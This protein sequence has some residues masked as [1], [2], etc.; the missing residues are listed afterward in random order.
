MGRLGHYHEGDRS[1]FRVFAP[2]RREIAVVLDGGRKINM[3][4]DEL[5]YWNGSCEH[6][7]Y[8][9]RY[10]VEVNGKAYPDPASK[11]QPNGVH[12]HS[13]VTEI[14]K[15]NLDDWKGI[16]MEDAIIYEL[17]LGTFTE[18]GDLRG[19]MEKLT[20]LQELGINVIELMPLNAFPGKRNWGYDGTYQFALQESYGTYADLKDFIERA[21]SLGIAVILDV[22]YNHFG[23][24]GNYTGVFAN[25]TK[26]A[27]TP[28][29]AAINFDGSYNYGIREFY[30]ENARYW[31]EDV[32]FDGFR[33]DAVSL[34]F[35][36]MPV[37]ILREI[38]DLVRGIAHKEDRHIIN[39]AEHLRNDRFVTNE[40][41]FNYDSQWNDDMNHAIYAKVTGE[42]KG[43]YTNFGGFE[44]V[45]KAMS[46]GFVLDGSRY[47]KYCR[48]FMGTSGKKT[49]AREHVVH[50]QN[51]DQLGNRLMGDRMIASY[52]LEKALLGIAAVL[53]TP[54]VP[55]LF[56]GEEYGEKA[57]FLFFE[58]FEDPKLVEAVKAGRK[59]EYGFGN[60]EPEPPHDIETFN[61][62]KLRWDTLESDEGSKI[63]GYY[64]TLLGLKKA[65]KLGPVDKEKVNIEADNRREIIKVITED[66][67]T[68]L[69]FSD[70]RH[71]IGKI[72]ELIISSENSYISKEIAPY[73]AQVYRG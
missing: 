52:G 30:L 59:R 67:I 5:G 27:P 31:L 6:L 39:I 24:E 32:G 10:K 21:H 40:S 43:H 60:I 2:Q 63:L 48:Y 15:A 50:I 69:N 8:G 38:T 7:P 3:S 64:K 18:E 1:K 4:K 54:Y 47:D 14:K 28:W 56:Q 35:D 13:M 20:Y 66:T 11:Y 42:N 22:V 55:M 25:Y 73:G 29:G 34:I 44:D 16:K 53:A 12:G 46:E 71:T 49:S 45:V 70:K 36:N 61:L 57:P 19:A 9:T 62:S 72:G 33:M 17:H 23:P 26:D 37:H 58:D 41:G 65:G 51:H 68:I